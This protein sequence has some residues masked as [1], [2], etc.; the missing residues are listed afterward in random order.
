VRRQPAPAKEPERPTL[1]EKNII[2]FFLRLFYA[3][4]FPYGKH[5]SY[6]GCPKVLSQFLFI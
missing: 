3:F 2:H 1:F 6:A 4:I 5:P